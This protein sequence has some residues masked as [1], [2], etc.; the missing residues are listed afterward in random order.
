MFV[1]VVVICEDIRCVILDRYALER[2]RGVTFF[3]NHFR[4]FVDL[5][6]YVDDFLQVSNLSFPDFGAKVDNVDMKVEKLVAWMGWVFVLDILFVL[7]GDD[8]S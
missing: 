1:D 3:E 2:P 8:V 7:V 5:Q 4:D 6:S